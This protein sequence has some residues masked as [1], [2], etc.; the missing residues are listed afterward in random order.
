MKWIKAYKFFESKE[1]IMKY[2]K[3]I[4]NFKTTFNQPKYI[5][6][7]KVGLDII[8][9]HGNMMI[10]NMISKKNNVIDGDICWK[11]IDNNW[12]GKRYVVTNQNRNIWLDDLLDDEY[13]KS[14]VSGED[15]DYKKIFRI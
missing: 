7:D 4:E 1:I 6:G 12:V 11:H 13:V 2:I 14:W 15:A 5:S 3:T 10:D 8:D 9:K